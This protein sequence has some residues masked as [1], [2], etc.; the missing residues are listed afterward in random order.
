ML[1]S[2]ML[3]IFIIVCSIIIGLLL[4]IPENGDSFRSRIKVKNSLLLL[5]GLILAMDT[6]FSTEVSTV[7]SV[8]KEVSLISMKSDKNFSGGLFVVATSN[9][10]EIATIDTDGGIRQE[11]IDAKLTVI[12]EDSNKEPSI[13]LKKVDEFY[14]LNFFTFLKIFKRSYTKNVLIVPKGTVNREFTLK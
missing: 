6:I 7:E 9:N 12:Y 8:E 4:F 3:I 14:I 10:Y 11:T 1:I 2:K 5:F 13:V